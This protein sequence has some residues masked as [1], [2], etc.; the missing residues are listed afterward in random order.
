MDTKKI[1]DFFWNKELLIA[2]VVIIIGYSFVGFPIIEK[3]FITPESFSLLVPF[4]YI[5]SVSLSTFFKLAFGG[6]D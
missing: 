6:E 4:A 3:K 1:K 5:S 2:V